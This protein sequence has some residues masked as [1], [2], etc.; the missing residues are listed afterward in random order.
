MSASQSVASSTDECQE[1]ME[2]R[3]YGC[4]KLSSFPFIDER[5][6][7]WFPAYFVFCSPLVIESCMKYFYRSHIKHRR[8]SSAVKELQ[9]AL[10]LLGYFASEKNGSLSPLFNFHLRSKQRS[11][12]EILL[13]LRLQ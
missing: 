5:M 8:C 4:S 7:K 1:K 13:L 9:C 2:F 3:H 10:L 12:N 11:L 6:N